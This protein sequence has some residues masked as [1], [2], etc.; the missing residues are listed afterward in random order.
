MF[1]VIWLYVSKG[2]PLVWW[3]G[4]VKVALRIDSRD[5]SDFAKK[6]DLNLWRVITSLHQ[7][8]WYWLLAVR[9]SDA[10][11]PFHRALDFYHWPQWRDTAG[12][13]RKVF[14]ER[15]KNWVGKRYVRCNLKKKNLARIQIF[16]LRSQKKRHVPNTGIVLLHQHFERN[17][18]LHYNYKGT[19]F[20]DI[21]IK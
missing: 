12:E 3:Y 9:R 1:W 6:I 19:I 13:S 11:E 14:S 17:D 16:F 18:E 5:A 21:I 10:S 15:L 7:G 2:R 8:G 4:G 20:P